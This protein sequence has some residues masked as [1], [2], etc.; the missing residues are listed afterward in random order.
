ME[1]PRLDKRLSMLRLLSDALD[2]VHQTHGEEALMLSFSTGGRE[3]SRLVVYTT[4]QDIA[5][6]LNLS[7]SEA[8]GLLK[9]LGRD[10][11][12]HLDYG[13]RGRNASAGIVNASFRERGYAAIEQ[14]PDPHQ[15]LLTALDEI[16]A[17]IDSLPDADPTD[18]EKAKEGVRR[19]RGFLNQLPAGVADE[20]VSRLANIFGVPGG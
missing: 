5:A 11:Y 15:Q 6:A 12:L 3:E 18:R 20:V 9:E 2:V 7:G 13:E 10:G 8:V 4:K 17:A 14:L 19:V 16:V 1:Y